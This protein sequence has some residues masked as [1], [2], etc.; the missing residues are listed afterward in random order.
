M[1]CLILSRARLATSFFVKAPDDAQLSQMFVKLFADRQVKVE[2]KIISYLVSRMERSASEVVA[3]VEIMDNL[4]MSENRAIS[5]KVA[6]EAI[7]IRE[8]ITD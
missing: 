7:V 1:S 5:R 3:L 2:P 6:S 8:E 4:A